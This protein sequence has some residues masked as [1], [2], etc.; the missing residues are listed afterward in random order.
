[1]ENRSDK[2]I[3]KENNMLDLLDKF[4]GIN[5]SDG[6]NENILNKIK[7]EEKQ[8]SNNGYKSFA[9]LAASIA[10]IVVIWNFSQ[11]KISD[12]S[13]Q[14]ANADISVIENLELLDKMEVLENL[15]V[16][17]DIESTRKFLQLL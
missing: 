17:E 9:I 3:A 14:I 5:L 13:L 10:A 12:N 4:D 8:I 6:F 16:L 15:D 11:Q 2:Q 7:K 1:M